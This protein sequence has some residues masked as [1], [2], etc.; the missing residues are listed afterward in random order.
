MRNNR[1]TQVEENAICDLYKEGHKVT[2]ICELYECHHSL[3]YNILERNGVKSIRHKKSNKRRCPNC[4][5]DGHHDKAKFCWKCGQDIRSS[6]EIAIERLGHLGRYMNGSTEGINE[7]NE[8]LNL[9]SKN[10]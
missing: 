2:E 7:L 9:L 5:A 6:V 1:F 10:N 3:V 4:N 8:I